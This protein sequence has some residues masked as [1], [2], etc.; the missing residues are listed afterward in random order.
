VPA[1]PTRREPRVSVV[2]VAARRADRLERCL[3]ALARALGESAH[4]AEVVLVLN[5]ADA[6]VRA[7]AARTTGAVQV[8]AAVG[9]GFA[10]GANLG[11][12]A[13]AGELVLLLHDDAEPREGWLDPLVAFLDANP[14]AGAVAGAA[15]LPDGTPQLAGA[16]LWSDAT[17]SPSWGDGPA[18]MPGGPLAVDYA[19]S[20]SLLVRRAAWERA[21]GADPEL[22]PAYYVDVDLS[23]RLRRAGYAVFCEP[24]SAILHHKS[25]SSSDR[26]RVF[27]SRRNRERFLAV[28]AEVLAGQAA[29]GDVAAGLAA[30]A[31]RA[32]RAAGAPPPPAGPL[33]APDRRPP[34]AQRLLAGAAREIAFRSALAAALE[35]EL[36]ALEARVAILDDTA[37]RSYR[38][39][40][41]AVAAHERVFAELQ[42]LRARLGDQ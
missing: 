42:A 40:A 20:A 22:H 35:E 23:M 36:A 25:S 10:D 31:A 5:G 8:D 17:T 14:G 9:L 18:R 11:V 4:P 32:A 6:G 12:G 37:V 28:W 39:A 30:A 38:D 34:S 3:A 33:P 19:G 41:E 21:G 27:A 15:Y 26:A 29:P 16:L 1:L 24:R 13:A 7:L 2:I